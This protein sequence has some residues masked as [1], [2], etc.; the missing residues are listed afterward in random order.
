[1]KGYRDHRYPCTLKAVL[2]S[3]TG[4]SA[5]EVINIS[6]AGARLVHDGALQP[7]DRVSLDLLPG[8]PPLEAQVR[9]NR[10]AMLGLRFERVLSPG[11]VSRLRGTTGGNRA[12]GPVHLH[13]GLRELR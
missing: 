3:K 5:T 13:P 2:H 6:Q 12:G 11:D 8:R 7:G 1:M 9:W 10:A 4:R